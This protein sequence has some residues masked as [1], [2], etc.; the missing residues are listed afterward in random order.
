MQTSITLNGAS[1]KW[2][3]TNM[4]KHGD[5]WNVI[6]HFNKLEKTLKEQQSQIDMLKLDLNGALDQNIAI[7]KLSEL[8]A[9]IETLGFRLNYY[10]AMIQTNYKHSDSHIKILDQFKDIIE[11]KINLLPNPL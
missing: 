7:G 11:A 9:A 6:N 8:E 10:S 1:A 4:F 2:F 3:L 5:E